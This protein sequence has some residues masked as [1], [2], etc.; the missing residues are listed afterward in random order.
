MTPA[1][2]ISTD[3]TEDVSEITNKASNISENFRQFKNNQLRDTVG[4]TANQNLKVSIEDRQLQ[5]SML[6]QFYEKD[7]EKNVFLN[8]EMS[9]ETRI[10]QGHNLAIQRYKYNIFAKQ[11]K[12]ILLRF[13]VSKTYANAILPLKSMKLASPF[14]DPIKMMMSRTISDDEKAAQMLADSK[15]QQNHQQ[16]SRFSNLS[17]F[18]SFS[19]DA[20]RLF[21]SKTVQTNSDKCKKA[22]VKKQ[23]TDTCPKMKPL[24][25]CP[26]PRTSCK[27]IPKQVRSTGEVFFLN[28]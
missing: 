14:P 6:P 12:I 3:T 19:T 16:Q 27:P 10:N 11:I 18:R 17:S 1:G 28:L 9:E 25:D 24:K 7:T 22:V 15:C 2:S 21:S 26:P 23:K 13:E 4:V 20:T 5:P 8:P